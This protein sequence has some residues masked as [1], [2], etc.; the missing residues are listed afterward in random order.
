MNYQITCLCGN[1]FRINDEQLKG[2]VIC[3]VCK[4]ALSPIVSPHPPISAPA[5]PAAAENKETAV[6]TLPDEPTKRCPYCGEVILAVAKKCKH[7]GEFLDRP[8]TAPSTV[9]GQS[10]VAA[11]DAAAEEPPIYELSVSQWDN[12]WKY[13]ICLGIAV[14]VS[15]VFI[16]WLPQYG[17]PGVLSTLVI[18]GLIAWFFYLSARN[19]R[20]TIRSV[21]IET[22]VGILSKDINTLELFRITDLSLKQNMMERLL[23]VGTIH[24]TSNDPSTPELMLYKIPQVKQVYK[25]LQQQVPIVARQRGAVYFEK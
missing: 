9:P 22:E 4:R 12:F 11:S 25:Y 10:T 23:G 17:M 20:C 19:S 3:S 2:P 15:T 18:L 14:V 1:Q 13:L 21:R 6:T 8:A 7:C 5:T 16:K 24:I